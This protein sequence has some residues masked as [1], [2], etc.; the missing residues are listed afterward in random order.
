MNTTLEAR[1]EAEFWQ[2]WLEMEQVRRVFDFY[3]PTAY[4]TAVTPEVTVYIKSGKIRLDFLNGRLRLDALN[5]AAE[6]K[7]LPDIA[8][9]SVRSDGNMVISLSRVRNTGALVT[10]IGAIARNY[11][12]PIERQAPDGQLSLF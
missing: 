12:R 2:H 6:I 8:G 11:T 1:I 3:D 7:R 9:A 4:R 5:I 10:Q